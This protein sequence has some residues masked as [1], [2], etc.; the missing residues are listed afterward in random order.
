M[1]IVGRT[2]AVA[3]ILACTSTCALARLNAENELLRGPSVPIEVASAVPDVDALRILALGH[4][5]AAAA[6]VWLN[7]LS[8]Y[9][10]YYQLDTD[11]A[12]LDP[13]VL[14]IA[15][16]D[17]KFRFVFEW[18][19][20]V[21]MYGGEINNESVQAANRILELGIQRFPSAW[22]LRFMLGVNYAFELR[23]SSQEQADE[24]RRIGA[25]HIAVAA[26]LPNAPPLLRVTSTSLLR[27]RAPWA[28]VTQTLREGYL[29]ATPANARTL[30]A[31]IEASL[32]A[33]E[34]TALLVQRRVSQLLAA[35]PEWGVGP[36]DFL[37]VLFPDPAL[38]FGVEETAPRPFAETR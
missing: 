22:S 29:A 28:D 21:I 14:A 38:R 7:A 35:D 26:T 8:F 25:E 27:G 4:N 9:G 31:Q 2:A 13:H 37:A 18:A 36:V 34:A 32:P 5:E 12:W 11:V 17:P 30:R 23:P 10:T 19:G 16:L 20:T 24:W 3:T 33:D 1:S 15:D 6:L